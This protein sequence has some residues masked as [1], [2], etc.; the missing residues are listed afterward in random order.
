MTDL[1]DNPPAVPVSAVILWRSEQL[2]G[3]EACRLFFKATHWHL[4]GAAVFTHEQKPCYLNFYINNIGSI[5]KSISAIT[6]MA[7][8]SLML[9]LGWGMARSGMSLWIF[10]QRPA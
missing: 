8:I 3:H 4:K 10:L 9:A 2:A 7:V 1:L 6:L 5:G